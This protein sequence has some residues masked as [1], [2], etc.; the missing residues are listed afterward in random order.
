MLVGVVV[1]LGV[2]AIVLVGSHAKI[3]ADTSALA[4]IKMPVGG[5]TLEGV[6]VATRNGQVI[7]TS[8]RGGKIWPQVLLSPGEQ[9]TVEATVR[10]PGWLSWLSGKTEHVHATLTTPGITLLQHYL[11]LGTG[12]RVQLSFDGAIQLLAYGPPGHQLHGKVLANPVSQVSL[13]RGS[14][15][16]TYEVAAAPRTWEKLNPTLVSWFPAGGRASAVVSPTPGAHITP[17]TPIVLSFSEPVSQAIGSAKPT[18]FPATAGR[19]LTI[20]ERT[21]EFR[22]EGYG[23][24][25]GSTVGV[26][27]PNTVRLLAAGQSGASSSS[28]VT[29]TVPAGSPLRADQILAQLGYLPY[30]WHSTGAEIAHTATA[31]VD[32]AIRPPHGHFVRRYDNTPS[33]LTSLWQPG[34]A[35]NVVARGAIMAFENDHDMTDDGI[36]SAAVWQAL[37]HAQD[38]HQ[39]SSFAGYTF[40]MVSQASET[41]HLWHDGGI[42]LTTAVNTGIA[43]A[44]TANGVFPVYEHIPVGTMSGT[45]PDGSTYSDPGIPWIS[46]F[47]GGDALHG[48]IRASYGFPQSLGCVEMP[49]ATAG[50]VYPYTPVGTL[51]DVYD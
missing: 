16:G 34:V 45:N 22:P 14:L 46:Y 13:E 42:A 32:A 20:N 9:L 7:P 2:A 48:F 5:G 43:S 35:D 19:W 47:N 37:I 24:P 51:V 31:Q 15:A 33:A 4:S 40:V 17:T 23:F 6:T 38:A 21:L 41:L 25:L 36:L 27:L 26:A 8:V 44:P 28:R 18:I 50:G 29:W 3:S 49:P 12:E 30:R 11:T 10:R 1:A 39:R